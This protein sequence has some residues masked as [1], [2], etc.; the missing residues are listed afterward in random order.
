MNLYQ[1]LEALRKRRTPVY[2]TT[3][4][5]RVLGTTRAQANTYIK[6]MVDKGL[7]LRVSKGIYALESDPVAYASYIVP[8]SYISFN[9]AL[10][11]HKKINQVPANVQ[12]A[13]PR[14]VRKKADGLE[15]VSLPKRMFFGYT[16]MDYKGCHI[17]VAEPEKAVVDLLYK[18]GKVAKDAMKAT[19]RQKIKFYQKKAG[20]KSRRR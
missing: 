9:T 7:L 17:W 20:V 6:R 11:L 8:N 2:P 5:A 13:V 14:R 1:C 3:E 16:K 19:D 18:Y 10:Y 12:V 15:F 4:I